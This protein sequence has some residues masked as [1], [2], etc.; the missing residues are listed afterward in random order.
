MLVPR[1]IRLGE[2]ELLDLVELVH[3]EHASR[4]ASGGAGLAAEAGREADVAQR[5]IVGVEDLA[6][7]EPAEGISA[8]PARKR[9][10]SSIA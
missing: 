8:V 3:P 1:V 4:V 5:Q 6:G 2:R 9:S 10:V 7:V